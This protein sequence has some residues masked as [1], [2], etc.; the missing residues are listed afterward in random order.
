MVDL[1]IQF[2]NSLCR[3]CAI[4]GASTDNILDHICIDSYTNEQLILNT[5]IYEYRARKM[6]AERAR[7]ETRQ[8]LIDMKQIS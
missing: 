8:M 4:F 1:R 3:L 5:R 2:M 6:L 7:E